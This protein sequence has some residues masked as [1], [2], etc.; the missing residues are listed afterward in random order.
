MIATKSRRHYPD[1]YRETL[2][3]QNKFVQLRAFVP[4]WQKK[5]SKLCVIE[6]FENPQQ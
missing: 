4:W 1:S 5:E 3:E 6:V 2:Y